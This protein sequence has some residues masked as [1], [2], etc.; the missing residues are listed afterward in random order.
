VHGALRQ[1][2]PRWAGAPI[3]AIETGLTLSLA[4]MLVGLFLWLPNENEE[5]EE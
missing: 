2:P 1:D 4:L 5:A 3:L